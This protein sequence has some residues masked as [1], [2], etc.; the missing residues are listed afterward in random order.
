MLTSEEKV[1]IEEEEKI[2][3]DSNKQEILN[4]IFST[5]VIFITIAFLLKCLGWAVSFCIHSVVF[6]AKKTKKSERIVPELVEEP[7]N[8]LFRGTEHLR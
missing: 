5:A 6:L 8:G 4:D 1:K 3:Y 2:R 7:A